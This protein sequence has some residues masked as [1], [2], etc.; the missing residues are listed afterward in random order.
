MPKMVSYVP[1]GHNLFWCAVIICRYI[2]TFIYGVQKLYTQHFLP[3]PVN[4]IIHLV[5]QCQVK[6]YALRKLF[7]VTNFANMNICNTR[8]KAQC[9]LIHENFHGIEY[10]LFVKFFCYAICFDERQN[11]R[12]CKRGLFFKSYCFLEAI[13]ETFKDYKLSMSFMF[14]R[15]VDLGLLFLYK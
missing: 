8:K 14:H 4:D 1:S 5:I 9:V 10:S 15:E 13:A 7:C 12:S 6:K 3:V 11:W 2:R